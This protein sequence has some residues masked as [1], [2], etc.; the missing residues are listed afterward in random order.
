MRLSTLFISLPF[1]STL[2]S[3]N[4]VPQF[5]H[6]Y[7]CQQSANNASKSTRTRTHTCTHTHMAHSS[8]PPQHLIYLQRL[9]N[10]IRHNEASNQ[11]RAVDV[12]TQLLQCDRFNICGAFI[13]I[14]F[15]RLNL[16]ITID[17][18]SSN[19][20]NNGINNN[21]VLFARGFWFSLSIRM[22]RT[23]IQ[24]RFDRIVIGCI[25]S[26]YDCMLRLPISSYWDSSCAV[27]FPTCIWKPHKTSGCFTLFSFLFPHSRWVRVCECECECVRVHISNWL[28]KF[29]SAI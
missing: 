10:K 9:K 26:H 16:R 29:D 28:G 20:N 12:A 2:L 27:R 25:H 6:F 4:P 22:S 1:C 21:A 5:H 7:F 18:I 15:N 19:T 3:I 23:R 8:Y 14:R 11:Q 13:D 24:C 17:I